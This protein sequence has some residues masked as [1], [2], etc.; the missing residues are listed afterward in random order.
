METHPY[1]PI[2]MRMNY[3][4]SHEYSHETMFIT[5]LFFESLLREAIS[6]KISILFTIFLLFK[7][8]LLI[9]HTNVSFFL[10]S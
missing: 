10:F 7:L 4:S 5:I 9:I 1:T 2:T 3:C 8:A 6:L